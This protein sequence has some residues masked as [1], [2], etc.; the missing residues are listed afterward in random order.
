[1]ILTEMNRLRLPG[2]V[3]F[4]P[5]NRLYMPETRYPETNVRI[6]VFHHLSPLSLHL[7]G[8]FFC[9]IDVTALFSFA[10]VVRTPL[11]CTSLRR[12]CFARCYDAIVLRVLLGRHSDDSQADVR[13]EV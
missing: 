2:E 9:S 3:T 10:R 7:V 5:L 4:M 1:M 13:A 6:D 11:F 12:H 8:K